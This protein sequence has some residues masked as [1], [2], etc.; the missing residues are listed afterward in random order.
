MSSNKPLVKWPGG[1]RQL[2]GPLGRYIPQDYGKYIEPFFGG[3][4]L[5]FHLSPQDAIVNDINA[6]LINFYLVLKNEPKALIN[7]ISKYRRTKDDYYRIRSYDVNSLSRVQRASRFLYLNK[8]CFNGLY[9]VNKSGNFNVP[10]AGY[11]NRAIYDVESI[12]SMSTALQGALI[13][14]EDF[15]D[16]LRNNAEEGDLIFLD[17]PYLPSPGTELFNRYNSSTFSFQDHKELALIV[18]ELERKGCHILLTSSCNNFIR[19]LYPQMNIELVPVRRSI[20][21]N[22]SARTGMEIIIV[23]KSLAHQP[24]KSSLCA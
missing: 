7:S 11:K 21:C 15:K 19:D 6:E 23:S 20:S 5:Y 24:L 18:A 4:A 2:L 3:G 17:P 9:R 14:N 13:K 12:Y 16:T 10:Y 1:K 8:S 22:G